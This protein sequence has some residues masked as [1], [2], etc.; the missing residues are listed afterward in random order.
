MAMAGQAAESY[1][2]LRTCLEYALYGFY[3]HK[4]PESAAIW[5]KRHDSL[6]AKRL[7]QNEFRIG[8]LFEA[9]TECEPT[10][11]RIAKNFYD[12]CIDFG[13]HPNEAALTQSL[14]MNKGPDVV[15]LDIVYLS[16]DN[17]SLRCCLKTVAQVGASVLGIFKI[18]F[19]ERFDITGLTNYLEHARNGL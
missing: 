18:V 12:W 1:A 16:G 10:K 19:K 15:K 17:L 5:L 3:I 4:K 14:K 7:V 13:A 9:L 11:S 2:I 6:E 8:S